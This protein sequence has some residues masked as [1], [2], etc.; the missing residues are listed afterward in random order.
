MRIYDPLPAE[1]GEHPAACDWLEYLRFRHRDGPRNPRQAD[2]VVVIIPGFL[3][4]AGSFDQLARNTVRRAAQIGREIE[5]WALD[6]RA[7][8]LEDDTG[9]RAAAKA[10]DSTLAYDYYWGG[11]QVEGQDLRRLHPARGGRVPRP[12]RSR[13]HDRGLVHGAANSDPEPAAAG[14]E[15]DL[16]R[17]LARRPADRGLRE[18]G[19]RRRSR[20]LDDAGYKQC[21]GLVG[22][23]T[24]LE[25]GGGEGAG[26]AGVIGAATDA[27]AGSGGAP[28]VNAPPLTP[29]TIQVPN[30]F[31]VG[32]YF[33]GSRHRPA[34]GA[35]AHEEHRSLP[36]G[37]V[38]ARCAQFATNT[39]S[40]RDFTLTNEVTLAGVFDDNSAPLSFLRASVG[41]V[42]GGPLV[43]KNFPTPSNGE[44]ALPEEP[45]TPLYAW[46]GYRQVGAGEIALND[47]GEPYTTREGEVS[48]L[49]QLARTMWEAPANFTEQYFPT[50]IL[51]DVVAAGGG[52]RS[53]ELRGAESTT[54]SP[55]AR[56]CWSRPAT[57]TT[58]LPPTRAS[59][60]P[61]TL[62]R[63]SSS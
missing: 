49:R 16:R 35:A 51:T 62:P 61:A 9:V 59:R 11:G 45:S 55:S 21:A 5:Y 33:E 52:D 37:P 15:G 63:T 29:E 58:T 39:P 6:R 56:R 28:Y 43:D 14:E 26:G 36:A 31:G 20:A 48:D 1:V 22:L 24:T 18:L 54:A 12:F 23:D 53:G 7:N 47:S 19:L 44:L 41:Q 4:G 17:P 34:A 42:V 32:A 3:G 60:S 57:P 8:C 13:A 50:R 2:A 30:V 10:G 27:L 40:I 38:L 46:E 25:L